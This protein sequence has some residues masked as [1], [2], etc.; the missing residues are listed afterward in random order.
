MAKQTLSEYL[1]AVKARCAKATKGPWR[2]TLPS[3]GDTVY[4]MSEDIPGYRVAET[5]GDS[6]DDDPAERDAD[7]IAH[8]RT[9]EE[10]LVTMVA[11][12]APAVS[13]GYYGP[14]TRERLEALVPEE[15]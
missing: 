1:E 13:I 4:I 3:S 8:S 6:S 2:T 11:L 7:F 12:L 5:Y 9:D 14:Q 10:V 15:K